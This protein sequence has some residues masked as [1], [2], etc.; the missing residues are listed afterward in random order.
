MLCITNIIEANDLKDREAID[1]GN[2]KIDWSINERYL[3]STLGPQNYRKRLQPNV[4]L[5]SAPI[6]L[7]KKSI[8]GR[9]QKPSLASSRMGV[10]K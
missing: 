5:A 6:G 1:L 2:P 8:P 3:G 4:S 10:N 7:N 9:I